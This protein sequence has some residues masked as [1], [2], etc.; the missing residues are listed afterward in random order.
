MATQALRGPRPGLQPLAEVA[1]EFG[2]G[3]D[4]WEA[5]GDYVAKLNP[6]VL[7][8][9]A[10]RPQGRYV[11][12]T[13]TTPIRQG[14]GKTVVALGLAQALRGLGHRVTATLRQPALAP[15]LGRTGGATGGGMA[16]LADADRINLHFTGDLSAVAAAHNL[17][18]A[19]VENH[20]HRGNRLHLA[21]DKILWRRVIDLNDRALRR[22]VIGPSDEVGAPARESGFDVLG[23]SE[24]MGILALSSDL[25]ELRLR[26]SNI[27]VGLDED[28]RLVRAGELGAAGIMTR[29]LADAFR[30]NLVQTVEGGPCLVHTS[31]YADFSIGSSSVVA[32]RIALSLSEFVITEVGMGSDCGVEKMV[33]LKCAQSGLKPALV[34][35]VT[36]VRSLKAH[37]GLNAR[38][39]MVDDFRS[40]QAGCGN[41]AH[42]LGVLRHFGLPAVVAVNRFP[43][44]T[45]AEC[46]VIFDE[47][48]KEGAV[49]SAS[50][51]VFRQG[52]QGGLDLARVVEY[53]SR[54][55]P[56]L[57]PCYAMD[58]PVVDKIE[59]VARKVY[60]AGEVSLSP[61]AEAMVQVIEEHG[62]GDMPVC[63]AKTS[64]SLSHDAGLLG[65]PRGFTL[66]VI[67]LTPAAGAGYIVVETP[68]VQRMPGLPPEPGMNLV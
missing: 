37:G 45:D 52:G 51:D 11:V 63:I 39:Q 24:V 10:G 58:D 15:Y 34:V 60:G 64:F 13:N 50:V 55:E 40:L 36:T 19:M 38:G 65:T 31:P 57:H 18:M 46:Q 41:L 7:D 17:L 62:M 25:R 53:A 3:P 8:R 1:R 5:Y 47:A 68:H 32:D 28:G 12:V 14:E 26:L 61:E 21:A 23:T 59:A 49:A 9:V 22:V 2:L 43:G 4:E 16:Q 42:H 44:D 30:P 33:H 6:Q 66:P 29:L 54:R 48:E 67:A 27:A 56:D 35:L 20:L